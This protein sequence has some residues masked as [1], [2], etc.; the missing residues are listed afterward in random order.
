MSEHTVNAVMSYPNPVKAGSEFKIAYGGSDRGVTEVIVTDMSG[1]VILNSKAQL[2]MGVGEISISTSGW[3]VGT[4]LVN[5]RT[6][7]REDVVR[8]VV[9]E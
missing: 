1:K 9:K 3:S 2:Q 5:L 7:E 6:G 8:V 4:Y